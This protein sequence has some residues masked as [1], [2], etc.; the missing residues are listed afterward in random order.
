MK[1]HNVDFIKAVSTESVTIEGERVW[2]VQTR[3]AHWQMGCC[4]GSGCSDWGG[5][6]FG[7]ETELFGIQTCSAGQ[8]GSHHRDV[9]HVGAAVGCRPLTAGSLHD[10]C[11]RLCGAGAAAEQV[12]GKRSRQN[13]SKQVAL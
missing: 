8:E 12:A 13:R 7:V 2:Y 11:R 1:E 9:I 4:L 3:M 5:Q 10:L 6:L